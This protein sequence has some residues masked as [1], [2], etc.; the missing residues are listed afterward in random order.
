MRALLKS[1]IDGRAENLRLT[2]QQQKLWE[3]LVFVMKLLALSLPLYFVMLFGI[4]IYPLQMLD[5][6]V[7]SSVLNSM[8][9]YVSNQ[10]PMVTVDGGSPFTFYLTEDCTAWKS[11][12]FL[13]A[14]VFA[15]PAVSMKKR[16]F[17][18]GLGIPILWLGNQA[19]IV[20]VVMTAEATSAQ[21]AM[22][23][24]D[25][26]WRIFL[27]F[28]VLGV[29][30]FWIKYPLESISGRIF[31]MKIRMRTIPRARVRYRPKAKARRAKHITKK[32]K[33]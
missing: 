21:F 31:P 18:F 32:T 15:V 33:R 26:F 17:G 24:H 10:G 6:S 20:G 2:Y 25:Y 16:L 13:F 3:T 9:Y 1:M 30:I 23:T 27:V 22:F 11:F 14:L 28:L 7:S 8:G 12:L 5:V 19:R 4:S 29:W